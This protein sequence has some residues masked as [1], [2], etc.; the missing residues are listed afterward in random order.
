[1]NKEIAGFV[2]GEGRLTALPSR[3]KK[4]LMALFYLAEQI[5]ADREYTEKEFNELLNTMHTFGDPATL[6]RELYDCFLINRE[7]NG[8]CY[9]LNPDRPGEEELL[10]S[11]C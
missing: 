7:E 11:C 10:E 2:D 5:P 1:M 8:R 9:R 3:K 4:K 6:R